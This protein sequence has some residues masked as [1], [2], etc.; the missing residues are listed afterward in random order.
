MEFINVFIFLIFNSIL[1]SLINSVKNNNNQNEVAI[2]SETSKGL[3]KILYDGAESL[4]APQ[5]QKYKETSKPSSSTKDD[6]DEKLK[7]KQYNK[8]RY[9]KKREYHREYARNWYK[10]NLER[11]QIYRKNNKEKKKEYDR[12]Y[13]QDNKEKMREYQRKYYLNKKNEKEIIKNNRLKLIN[14][15][16]VS[17][18]CS[19]D[20]QQTEDCSHKVKLPIVYEED[21]QTEERNI[22][23]G[24]EEGNNTDK[25]ENFV[26]DLNQIEVEEPN[27]LGEN[28]I[29][30][31]NLNE[32]PFDLNEKPEEAEEDI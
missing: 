1:W 14:V 20:I 23:R 3:N 13:L 32:Y 9:Q 19:F 24:W 18:G 26:D 10:M 22:P 12:K 16:S 29:N 17:E 27:K 8:K 7:M 21:F 31:I 2:V 6:E 25:V 5:I 11:S 4:G 30:Q 28:N 15:Q